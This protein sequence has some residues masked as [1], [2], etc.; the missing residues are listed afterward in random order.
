MFPLLLIE[1][2]RPDQLQC[3]C[4]VGL[5]ITICGLI[6]L[7]SNAMLWLLLFYY[8]FCFCIFALFPSIALVSHFFLIIDIINK[9]TYKILGNLTN[10]FWD[11]HL[12]SLAEKTQNQCLHNLRHFG[13]QCMSCTHQIHLLTLNVHSV[14]YN[15]QWSQIL[16]WSN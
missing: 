14:N 16:Y 9:H 2:R 3:Y 12:S 4:V 10:H 15:V 6:D 13:Q 11:E 7:R 1:A 5:V 8:H